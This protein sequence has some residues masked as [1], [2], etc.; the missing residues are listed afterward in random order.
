[1]LNPLLAIITQCSAWV[2][3]TTTMVMIMTPQM[4]TT[5]TRD[6]PFIVGSY[7]AALN[8]IAIMIIMP[9]SRWHQNKKNRKVNDE[10]LMTYTNNE[11]DPLQTSH[12]HYVGVH[13]HTG[14]A[15]TTRDLL[16]LIKTWSN[17]RTWHSWPPQSRQSTLAPT[18]DDKGSNAKE[19]CACLRDY[20]LKRKLSWLR[21]RWSNHVQDDT[22][23][24]KGNWQ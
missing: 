8:S 1:L 21:Y 20:G 2:M 13:R 16:S 24:T 23:D 10:G 22:R 14:S 17:I 12:S 11:E 3:T 19:D 6:H 4:S 9:K 7:H 5:M 15:R 18:N